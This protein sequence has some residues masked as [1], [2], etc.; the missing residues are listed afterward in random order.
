MR[1]WKKSIQKD[2][3]QLG[4][5]AG[6]H[7]LVH[8]SLNAL[9][10]FPDRATI[11]VSALLEQLGTKGTLLMPALSYKTVTPENPFSLFW[12]RP[13]VSVGCRNFSD[14]AISEKKHPPHAFGLCYRGVK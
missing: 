3:D 9:G 13:H 5:G 14:A 1:D 2:L 6:D 12:K 11:V 7:L 4:I 8:A 10:K